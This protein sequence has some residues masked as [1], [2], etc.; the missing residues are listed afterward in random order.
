MIRVDISVAHWSYK[1]RATK[2][3]ATLLVQVWESPRVEL[4][5]LGYQSCLILFGLMLMEFPNPPSGLQMSAAILVRWSDAD[6]QDWSTWTGGPIIC[7]ALPPSTRPSGGKWERKWHDF[8]SS[9]CTFQR[10]IPHLFAKNT[11]RV[12]EESPNCLTFHEWTD[13]FELQQ[14]LPSNS[15][16]KYSKIISSPGEPRNSWG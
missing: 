14:W 9:Y 11:T 2:L 4:L 10:L 16:P 6:P 3:V 1:R 15:H 13:P 8:W 7:S 5:S 12:S